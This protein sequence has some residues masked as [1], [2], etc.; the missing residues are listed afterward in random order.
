MPEQIPALYVLQAV[1]A[2]T[3]GYASELI[4][5]SSGAAPTVDWTAAQDQTITLNAATVTFTFTAPLQ[6][7]ATR[8]L[9]LVQDATGGRIAAW[10]AAVKW[11]APYSA[12]SPPVLTTA[13]SAVDIA[14]FY[15]NGTNYYGQ[16]TPNFS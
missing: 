10:P 14:V 1:Q 2:K 4:F 13:P 11:A 15:W 16:F 9:R 6:G 3:T 7:A 5:G 12:A 8:L